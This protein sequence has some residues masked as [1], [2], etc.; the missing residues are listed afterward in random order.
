[1]RKILLYSGAHLDNNTWRLREVPQRKAKEAHEGRL[2]LVRLRAASAEDA[3]TCRFTAE[4]NPRRP[5]NSVTDT[6]NL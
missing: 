4:T 1:M 5:V 3:A 6:R 2:G